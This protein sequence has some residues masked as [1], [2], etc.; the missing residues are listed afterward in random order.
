MGFFA[1]LV[2]AH[3]VLAALAVS[4]IQFG[5]W[6]TMIVFTTGCVLA[7]GAQAVCLEADE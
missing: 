2:I 6:T 1:Q 5:P 3:V 4:L 7:V